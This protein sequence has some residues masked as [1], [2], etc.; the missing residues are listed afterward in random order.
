MKSLEVSRKRKARKKTL[1]FLLFVSG[2][3]PHLISILSLCLSFCRLFFFPQSND[4][5]A[6]LNSSWANTGSLKK[7]FSGV[8]DLKFR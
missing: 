4:E 5:D 7:H 8:G 6:Y 1:F 2:D 3:R